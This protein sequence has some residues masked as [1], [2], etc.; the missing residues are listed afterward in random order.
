MITPLQEQNNYSKSD[1]SDI[2]MMFFSKVNIIGKEK[3][4]DT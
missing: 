4:K 2:I 3:K 1:I